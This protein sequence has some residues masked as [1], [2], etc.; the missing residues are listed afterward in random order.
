MS[1]YEKDLKNWIILNENINNYTLS[2]L[3][4]MLKFETNNQNRKTFIKRIQQRIN[5][6]ASTK[7]RIYD[8]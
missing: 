4:S 8:T 2:E 1:K 7:A 6:I 5:G 3:K